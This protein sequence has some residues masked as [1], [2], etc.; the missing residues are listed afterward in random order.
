MVTSL[1]LDSPDALLKI[2]EQ[3]KEYYAEPPPTCQRGRPRTFSG[4]AFLLLAVVAVVVRT[5]KPQELCTLLVKDDG[6]RQRLGFSRVPHRCT[7]ARRLDATL[8]E[9]EAQVQALGQRILGA[10]EPGPDEPQAS[11]ID[12]RMYQA[13]G[14]LWHK[15]DRDQGRV[16]SGLRNVD[17][18]SAWSKSGYR[19]WVQGYRLVLQSLV[20][21]APVP[22]F[23]RWC[24]NAVGESTVLAEA[25][26]ADHLPITEL[27]LGDS[28]FGGA[29][30]V[31]TYAQHDGWLLTP[32][33]LPAN[34]DSWKHDLYAYR[35]ETIELLFQRLMQACDL[36][37][38]P[39]K[40]LARSGTF[41][42]ACVWLY[43]VLFLD[44]SRHHRPLA[45]IKEFIDDARWRIAA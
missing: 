32:Q 10:V 12:G 42:L 20:F 26:A 1:K 15:R 34:P 40:G 36:K 27:L 23:A 30:L 21:P 9:A 41:V 35:R 24:S 43:Q 16:P 28:T 11:A 17:T 14:P 31:A 22:L 13:Q 38:C 6:L 2:V 39:A 3:V 37:A 19:G 8:P 4:R 33:Q 29:A 45:Q 18:E 25:L 44:N 7:M 5:F